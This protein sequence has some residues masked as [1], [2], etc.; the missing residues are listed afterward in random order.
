MYTLSHTLVT[1]NWCS[2]VS[3]LHCMQCQTSF[4]S[5]P[6]VS[7][8]CEAKS[9][10][11]QQKILTRSHT[12]FELVITSSRV[13]KHR[14]NGV[15]LRTLFSCATH[16][17][18]LNWLN[19]SSEKWVPLPVEIKTT[20]ND[21]KLASHYQVYHLY[22]LPCLEHSDRMETLS[23]FLSL[24]QAM[25]QGHSSSSSSAKFTYLLLWNPWYVGYVYG[26]LVY[27]GLC[28]IEPLPGFNEH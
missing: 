15:L 27:D 13:Y 12:K 10:K 25:A 6:R 8:R 23:F 4:P 16:F 5:T 28:L 18:A 26:P 22:C 2:V 21:E 1:A 20:T 3:N 7:P 11:F 14:Q 17:Q 19:I 24:A 9:T